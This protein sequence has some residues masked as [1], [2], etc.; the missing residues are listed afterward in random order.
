MMP[1]LVSDSEDM[2][3]SDWDSLSELSDE[4]R[5][6]FE[7]DVFDAALFLDPFLSDI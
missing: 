7:E 1:H 5:S 6:D 4:E 3:Q 2:S